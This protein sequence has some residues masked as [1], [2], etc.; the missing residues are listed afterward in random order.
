M[1]LSRQFK[2]GLVAAILVSLQMTA[3]EQKLTQREN[4]LVNQAQDAK[5]IHPLSDYIPCTFEP[6]DRDKFHAL[7]AKA[8][9]TAIAAARLAASASGLTDQQSE[10]VTKEINQLATRP[11]VTLLD[12][13]PILES[14]LKKANERPGVR[15]SAKELQAADI[16]R[17][18]ENTKKV[19]EY[20]E[21]RR[22]PT[23][24][25]CSESVLTYDETRDIFGRR[26][27][28]T[29]IAVQVTIRNLDPDHEFLIHDIQIAVDTDRF[30]ATRDKQ[31][32]AGVAELGQLLSPRN[33]VMRY[34]EGGVGALGIA[35][36]PLVDNL[37]LSN[38]AHGFSGFLPILKGMFPDFT[39]A[40][41][42]RLSNLGFSAGSLTYVIPKSG[43]HSIVTFVPEK[44][45]RNVVAKQNSGEGDSAGHEIYKEFK[46][47]TTEDLRKFQDSVE[48]L[49][50]GVHI[51]PVTT[52]KAPEV[53]GF[54]C[55][56]PKPEPPKPNAPKANEPN[57]SEPKPTGATTVCH[58]T[59]K[60]LE[61]VKRVKLVFKSDSTEGSAVSTKVQVDKTDTTKADVTF[62][63]ESFNSLQ[64]DKAYSVVLVN[65]DDVE[66]PTTT[67][68]TRKAAPQAAKITCESQTGS[69]ATASM[70]CHLEGQNLNAAKEVKL[71]DADEKPVVST[72]LEAVSG[73]GTK[74]NATFTGEGLSKLKKGQTYK[75]L[76]VK[77]DG[78][79]TKTSAT[80]EPK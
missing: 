79:D 12:I 65:Q 76:L 55:D 45:F 2:V 49:V 51:Q 27:A 46:K 72:K 18:V 8:S 68:F 58:L 36:V 9:S 4:A 63:S 15:G 80:Y 61:S 39:V 3:Q 1:R 30:F 57:P 56:G 13:A 43:S 53:T 17:V 60:N 19:A 40:Q 75:V 44:V 77:E 38:V 28:N 25:G 21:S 70:T 67:T 71:Q 33:Q 5:A 48:I 73:D 11:D 42:T 35:A 52:A 31:I 20:L 7:F 69:G 78:S 14:Q 74:A 29:Y 54:T 64:Q 16:A 10:L 37:D 41:I 59:G 24:I 47:Y 66:V 50:A 32:A 6:A 23:N 34:V 22:A 26:M 62:T